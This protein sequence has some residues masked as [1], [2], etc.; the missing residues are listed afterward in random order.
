LTCPAN[1]ISCGGDCFDPETSDL[2]C[3]AKGPTSS[4]CDEGNVCAPGT[5]CLAGSCTRPAPLLGA[6]YGLA[7]ATGPDGLIHVVGGQ[8]GAT[9]LN[10]HATF[11][12]R[13]NQ[14]QRATAMSSERA[15]L[16]AAWGD[17]G[18]LHA[19]GGAGVGTNCALFCST[20]EAYQPSSELWSY[21]TPL[22]NAL[23][24]GP[25]VAA[26]PTG[27]LYVAGGAGL[28]VTVSDLFALDPLHPADGGWVTLPAMSSARVNAAASFASD[29]RLYVVGGSDGNKDLE[30]LEAFNPS[31][32]TWDETLPDLPAPLRFLGVVGYGPII[33]TVGGATSSTSSSYVGESTVQGL[34]SRACD[35]GS[36]AWLSFPPLAQARGGHAAVLGPDGRLYAIG[37]VV[38]FDAKNDH[39]LYDGLPSVEIYDPLQP[40]GGWVS[41]ICP[42]SALSFA[43][44]VAYAAS[45]DAGVGLDLDV[46]DLNGDGY[47]DV[48]STAGSF[49]SSLLNRGNGALSAAST[50][51]VD[52]GSPDLRGLALVDLDGDGNLDVA[53]VDRTNDLLVTALGTGHGAFK[54]PVYYPTSDGGAA[55]EG[56]ISVSVGDFNGDGKP[57]LAVANQQGSTVG[58]FLNQGTFL[59]SFLGFSTEYVSTCAGPE[60][61]AAA[62]FNADGNLDLAVRCPNGTVQIWLGSGASSPTFSQGTQV[63]APL[64][65]SF[66]LTDFNLDGLPDI[67]VGTSASDAGVLTAEVFVNQGG[68]PPTFLPG[69]HAAVQ[70][71]T[72]TDEL[73]VRAVDIDGD[74]YPDVVASDRAGSAVFVFQNQPAAASLVPLPSSP[75]LGSSP[76]AI[77]AADM[78]LDGWNDVLTL[79]ANSGDNAVDV[80][81]NGCPP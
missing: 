34:D 80:W 56:P 30:S 55:T 22:P 57:D 13:S 63:P 78:R 48:V 61:A 79:D 4:G 39:K 9:T 10:R 27:V 71:L 47:P 60:A 31:A 50:F 40:D 6:R 51:S 35:A 12:P 26:S 28:A 77:H 42:T 49:V 8:S 45:V 41:S 46:G 69:P 7:A 44:P 14:W 32:G 15:E 64:A 58:V 24:A 18:D 68:S 16:G 76:I 25:A 52:A 21:E 38:E 62:D 36:C 37:G 67:V 23:R 5:V 53:T 20:N 2:H 54:P 73:A 43:S 29:G 17:D 59:G 74:G 11:D 72:G 75:L 65:A 81:L 66:A 1:Q 3:G 70:A 19:V 33:F